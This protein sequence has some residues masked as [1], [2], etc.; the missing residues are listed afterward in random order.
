MSRKLKV[1]LWTLAAILFCTELIVA[2]R[3]TDHAGEARRASEVAAKS[4]VSSAP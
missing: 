4:S 3:G 2:S 1:L